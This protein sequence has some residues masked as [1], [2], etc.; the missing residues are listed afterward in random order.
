M[1]QRDYLIKLELDQ[2]GYLEKKSPELLE[3]P[4]ANAGYGNFTIFGRSYGLDGQPW[5]HMVQ[6][7][8][9]REAGLIPDLQFPWTASCGIGV[10][11]FKQRGLW[12]PRAGAVP[13]SG[14]MIYF[15]Q[16]GR[17]PIHVG[18]VASVGGGRVHTLEGN[19][20][21][22]TKKDE[23]EANGG[24]FWDKSYS[25]GSS[26]IL[27]YGKIIYNEEIEI[28]VTK[29]DLDNWYEEKNP[30]Y[31]TVGSIPDEW[32]RTA[33]AKLVSHKVINGG[34]EKLIMPGEDVSNHPVNLRRETLI[35]IVAARR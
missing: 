32:L 29:K 13:E 35:A 26:W 12:I 15:T 11:W 31:A 17:T 9:M 28:M 8:I 10:N 34:L 24:G 25:L 2:V 27:G 14:M 18:L 7:V 22:Q 19:T 6:A 30:M 1:N 5:C 20:S 33:V 3:D 4:A 16:N 23:L 21:P